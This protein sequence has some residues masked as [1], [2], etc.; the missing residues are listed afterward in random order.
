MVKAQ[1]DQSLGFFYMAI[2]VLCFVKMLEIIGSLNVNNGQIL[3]LE[4]AVECILL[5]RNISIYTL[6]LDIPD[7][8]FRIFQA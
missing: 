7:A 8:I 2:K 6:A 1:S 5:R 3:R 4:S